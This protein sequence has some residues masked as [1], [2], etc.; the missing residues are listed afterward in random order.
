MA[1]KYE[2][3]RDYIQKLKDIIR[4]EDKNLALSQM[5]TLHP[6]DLA[7]IFDFLSLEEVLFLFRLLDEE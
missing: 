6:A 2:I 4:A 3:T 1:H 7:E 5:A